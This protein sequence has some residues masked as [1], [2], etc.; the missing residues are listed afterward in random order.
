[1]SFQQSVCYITDGFSKLTHVP[2]LGCYAVSNFQFLASQ[3]NIL[4]TMYKSSKK[5]ATHFEQTLVFV[6][7]MPEKTAFFT[8][9]LFISLSS[10]KKEK[11]ETVWQISHP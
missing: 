3:Q 10:D 1:M 11:I 4:F 7:T 5:R 2:E 9:Q 6:R 8:Y